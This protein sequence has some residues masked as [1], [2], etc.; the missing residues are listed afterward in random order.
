MEETKQ[1]ERWNGIEHGRK[2]EHAKIWVM[3]GRGV[4]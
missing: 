3:W 1:R 4:G 2:N